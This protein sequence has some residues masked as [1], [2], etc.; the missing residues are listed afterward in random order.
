M[1][2][3]SWEKYKHPFLVWNDYN[4]GMNTQPS[5][6]YSSIPLKIESRSKPPLKTI[7]HS[8]I[9]E[10]TFA[11][12]AVTLRGNCAVLFGNRVKDDSCFEKL[13][14]SLNQ[15]FT[16]A[17]P[18]RNTVASQTSHFPL[19]AGRPFF[20]VTCSASLISLWARHFRQ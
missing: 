16:S 8:K 13:W 17:F 2:G 1:D 4:S 5:R 20:N 6:C 10:R 14:Q 12:R 19:V 18:I 3:N 9:T 15:A 7:A 11:V